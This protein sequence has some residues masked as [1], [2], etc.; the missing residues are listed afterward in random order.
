MRMLYYLKVFFFSFEFAFLLLCLI[1]YM[2]S[3]DFFSQYFPLRSMNDEAIRWVMFFPIGITVWT[4]KEGVGVL[5]PSEK[6]EKILHE[7]P[8]YWKLKVHFDVGISNSIFFTIPCIVVWLL[9]TLNTL[10]GAWIFTG[11]AGALSINAFS[12]Y[13]AKISLR[14][15]L[16]RLDDD[17][18]YDNHVK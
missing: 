9:D 16:I 4:L 11:F 18:N 3:D 15:A 13:A 7:W 5:F 1:V 8:D 12:F 6:N 14:S 2:L 17:N 10:A